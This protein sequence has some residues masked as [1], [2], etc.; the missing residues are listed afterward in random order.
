MASIQET[1]TYAGKS[2]SEVYQAMLKAAPQA[3]LQIWKRRDIGW[4]IMVRS[5]VGK[6]AID[7]NVSARPGGQA[8]VSLSSSAL[9]EA[10]L[11]AH[12]ERVFSEMSK[13]L[14]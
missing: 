4:L 2:A 11:Q 9:S 1:R 5:S 8:T 3:G 13:I 7:G 6:A 10:E 12:A 14:G